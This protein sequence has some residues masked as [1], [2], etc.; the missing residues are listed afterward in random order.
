MREPKIDP[1]PSVASAV[2]PSFVSEEHCYRTAA[3]FGNTPQ[4]ALPARLAYKMCSKSVQW[5]KKNITGMK[6]E[7]NL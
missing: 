5:I 3:S 7:S 6:C 2:L 4:H 1:H